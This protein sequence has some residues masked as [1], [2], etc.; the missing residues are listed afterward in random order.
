MRIENKSWITMLKLKNSVVRGFL[1]EIISES[2][3]YYKLLFYILNK[4]LNSIPKP[5]CD[6]QGKSL[7]VRWVA[8]PYHKTSIYWTQNYYSSIK[9]Y[10]C[11]HY[12]SLRKQLNLL[13]YKHI[14]SHSSWNLIGS[15]IF[16]LSNFCEIRMFSVAASDLVLGDYLPFLNNY[17]SFVTC[18]F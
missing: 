18:Y 3:S 15:N 2:Y 17:W 14:S 8:N 1:W 10:N 11:L 6:F 13:N 16:K 7:E 5:V 12:I 9:M 4:S